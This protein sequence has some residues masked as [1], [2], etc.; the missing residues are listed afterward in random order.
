M[1]LG[2]GAS[3]ALDTDQPTRDSRATEECADSL[4]QYC[5]K[6]PQHAINIGR[7]RISTVLWSVYSRGEI[8]VSQCRVGEI[9]TIAPGLRKV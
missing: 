2:H 1:L 6:Q 5:F 3:C 8:A 4:L 7:A 9:E